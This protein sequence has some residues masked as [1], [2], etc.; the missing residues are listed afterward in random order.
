MTYQCSH[1]V[2][3]IDMKSGEME[4]MPI[5][6]SQEFQ[7]YYQLGDAIVDETSGDV[8]PGCALDGGTLW[9]PHRVL[10]Q[11]S[12]PA[13]SDD[14]GLEI[15]M[16]WSPSPGKTLGLVRKYSKTGEFISASCSSGIKLADKPIPV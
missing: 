15:S 8:E 13:I 10:L 7:K 12:T 3:D 1:A 9:L 4:V 2:E 5:Y 14:L 16:L 11:I 6:T